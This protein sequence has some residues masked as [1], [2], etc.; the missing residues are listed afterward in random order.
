MKYESSKTGHPAMEH[1]GKP[2]HPKA[3]AHE[4]ESTAAEQNGYASNPL[5]FPHVGIINAHGIRR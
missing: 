5:S 4:H 2:L 1:E 3:S